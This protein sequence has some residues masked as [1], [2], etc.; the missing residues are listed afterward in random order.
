M[1]VQVRGVILCI[2]ERESEGRGGLV[3]SYRVF[4]LFLYYFCGFVILA[5]KLISI[6]TLAAPEAAGLERNI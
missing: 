5:P 6:S 4:T 3:P 2:V 1:W